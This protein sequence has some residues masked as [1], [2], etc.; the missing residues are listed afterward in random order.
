MSDQN[1]YSAP[2]ASL[3]TEQAEAYQPKIFTFEGRI[4]RLRY[5][6]YGIGMTLILMVVFMPLMGGSMAFSGPGGMSI[7]VMILMG[8]FYLAAIILSFGFAKRR[9]ND[10]NR[11]GW[12]MLLFFVPIA[13]ILITIYLIF[14]PGSNEANHYGPPPVANSLGVKILGSLLPVIFVLGIIAAVAV[15]EY[16]NYLTQA[17]QMQGQ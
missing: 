8:I 5:L 14:F 15:P 4:G 3:E 12:W 16:Q 13:N 11:A 2:D 6:A 9:L 10:L 1:P 17:A 7:I